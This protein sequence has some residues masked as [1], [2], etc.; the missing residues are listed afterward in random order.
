MGNV[1]F[2]SHDRTRIPSRK[3]MFL[4]PITLITLLQLTTVRPDSLIALS[5]EAAALALIDE[6]G[7]QPTQPDVLLALERGWWAAATSML[8][9]MRGRGDQ[10]GSMQEVR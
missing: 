10:V 5:T 3:S 1:A 7:L 9:A 6:G 2:T 8:R 4:R